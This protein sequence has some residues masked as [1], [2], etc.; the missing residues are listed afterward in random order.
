[1]KKTIL[2]ICIAIC[3]TFSAQ[4]QDANGNMEK[5]TFQVDR[6]ACI[7]ANEETLK[8][9]GLDAAQITEVKAIQEA[10]KQ[11]RIASKDLQEAM[12]SLEVQEA[13]FKAVLTTEQQ[14]KYTTWCQDQH[15]KKVQ[16]NDGMK[17]WLWSYC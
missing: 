1:M 5:P 10:T 13:A 6:H 14:A 15:G 8:S 17:K 2:T 11:G 4:A 12:A 9:I 3:T 16:P 7:M